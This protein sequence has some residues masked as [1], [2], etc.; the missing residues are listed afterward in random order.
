MQSAA[1]A[2]RK[3][4]R[5]FPDCLYEVIPTIDVLNDERGASDT[6]L[7]SSYGPDFS[8][9]LNVGCL[10][11]YTKRRTK[12]LDRLLSDGDFSD[13]TV[14]LQWHA[15]EPLPP[16][17]KSIQEGTVSV[18]LSIE[19]LRQG[20][21]DIK[22][23]PEVEIRHFVDV[24]S[25]E[26]VE[27]VAAAGPYQNLCMGVMGDFDIV[28]SRPIQVVN[29]LDID[30]DRCVRFGGKVDLAATVHTETKTVDVSPYMS[31]VGHVPEG[32]SLI[33]HNGDFASDSEGQEE[34][35]ERNSSKIVCRTCGS[36]LHAS[37]T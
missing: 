16:M 37:S 14:N 26:D 30:L 1:T 19:S 23:R 13:V 36:C 17:P 12:F 35:N 34:K 21:Q 32:C 6:D 25:A 2:S 27:V 33:D 7:I 20:F 29:R 5:S 15:Q 10:D 31:V 3:R 18:R 24:C 9:T 22:A 11:I 8:V 28:P 4:Y